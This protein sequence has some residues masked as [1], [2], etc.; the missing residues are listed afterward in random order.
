MA[1]LPPAAHAAAFHSNTPG[2]VILALIAA[3]VLWAFV[4]WVRR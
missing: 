3:A 4:R 1:A 2:W